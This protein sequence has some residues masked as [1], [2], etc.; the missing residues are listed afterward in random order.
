MVR[1]TE[2]IVLGTDVR[3]VDGCVVVLLM[4][5]RDRSAE[6]FEVDRTDGIEV[7]LMLGAVDGIDV[8]FAHGM[9]IGLAV[10]MANGLTLGTATSKASCLVKLMQSPLASS[11]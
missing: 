10:G 3:T 8:G 1:Y 4:G 2:G 11:M 7:G 5:D 6:S 9:V